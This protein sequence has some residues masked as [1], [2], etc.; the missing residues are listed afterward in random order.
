M[1]NAWNMLAKINQDDHG[2]WFFNFKYE[3]IEE[4]KDLNGLPEVP[5][6]V[7]ELTLRNLYYRAL[8]LITRV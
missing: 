2:Y 4:S 6:P 3:K 5:K 1:V 7:T 8:S